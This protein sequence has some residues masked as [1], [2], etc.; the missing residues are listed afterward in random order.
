MKSQP[1]LLVLSLLV[2]FHLAAQPGNVGNISVE[3]GW[4]V[5]GVVRTK[6]GP[7]KDLY[8]SI[9]G[10]EVQQRPI[11]TDSAGRYRFTGSIPG[12]YTISMQKPEDASAAKPRTITVAAGDRVEAFDFVVPEGAVIAGKVMDRSG[13]PVAGMVVVAYLRWQSQGRLRLSEKGGAVADDKGEYRIAHLPDGIYVIAAVPLMRKPLR[14]VERKSKTLGPLPPAYPSVTFAPSGRNVADAA[15]IFARSGAEFTNADIVMEKVP[16]YCVSFRPTAPSA[17]GAQFA[18]TLVEWV[19]TRGPSMVGGG[20]VQSGDRDTQICGMPEGEYQLGLVAYSKQ[21]MKG[22]GYSNQTVIVPRRDLEL[23]PIE[24]AGLLSLKGKLRVREADRDAPLPEGIRVSLELLN[25]GLLPSDV[26]EGFVRED[27]GFELLQVYADTYGLRLDSLPKGYYIVKALQAG[28]DV[29]SAGMKP[30]DQPVEIELALDGPV[31]T[32]RVLSA[33]D[34][35]R[36][37]PDVPVLLLSGKNDV[38]QAGSTDQ[39]GVYT[40]TSGVPPGTY[41]LT[42]LPELAEPSYWTPGMSQQYGNRLVGIRLQANENKIL[43]LI[44]P[45]SQ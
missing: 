38:I 40:F 16:V 2:A 4:V 11:R 41:R 30:G 20:S 43:D 33:G 12:T 28:Q 9:A 44:A 10:P 19:G 24:A 1:F 18:V 13:R 45:Q 42:A 8:M 34:D 22:L 29:L 26:L 27:G 3:N 7:L 5:S 23:G 21:P 25:R 36:P 35:P 6:A 32:G 37:L 31:L 14:P 39:S 17:E 15:P